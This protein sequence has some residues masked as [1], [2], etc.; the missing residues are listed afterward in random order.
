MGSTQRPVNSALVPLSACKKEKKI[1][2]L[3]GCFET[4]TSGLFKGCSKHFNER[5]VKLLRAPTLICLP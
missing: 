5:Y 2:L 4:F 1:L 3:W